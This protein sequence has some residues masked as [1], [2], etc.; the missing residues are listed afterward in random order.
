MNKKIAYD[1]LRELIEAGHLELA[2]KYMLESYIQHDPNVNTGRKGF[3]NHISTFSKPQPIV[4]ASKVYLLQ[5]LQKEILLSSSINGNCPIPMIQPKSIFLQD[6]ICSVL[7]TESWW[8]IGCRNEAV[9]KSLA[10]DSFLASVT[11]QY[12]QVDLVSILHFV[13]IPAS[14][15]SEHTCHWLLEVY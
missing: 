5:S 4:I 13:S 9:T 15:A 3:I 12:Y 10:M 14:N 7:K 2:E 8:S 11:L 6:L 1:F